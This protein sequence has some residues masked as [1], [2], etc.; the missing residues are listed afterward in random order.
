[1][2]VIPPFVGDE[3]VV[4]FFVYMLICMGEVEEVEDWAAVTS[5][6]WSS[7]RDFFF[8]WR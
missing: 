4:L 2:R 3:R 5:K 8:G 7:Q 6:L 1:V